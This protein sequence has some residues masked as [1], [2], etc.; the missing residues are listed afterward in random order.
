MAGLKLHV[1]CGPKYIPGFVHLDALPADHV[2]HVGRVENLEMFDDGSA[3]LI[4]ASHILE[5]FG[6]H[7]YEAVLAEWHRVLAPGGVLRLAV[8]DFEACARLY[9]AGRLERGIADVVGLISG[10][11]KDQYDYHAMIFDRESLTAALQRVGFSDVRPWDWRKTEH[12]DLDDFSQAYLPHM[13][14]E[15]GTLVS[16]N[17]EAVR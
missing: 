13:Q 5:H 15:T 8:P 16:L 11:Q 6:R 4:Y 7:Q 14:K 2:D 17:L 9:V 10:G 3:E 12:A 1:G